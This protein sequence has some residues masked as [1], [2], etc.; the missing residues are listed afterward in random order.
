MQAIPRI[1]LRF[2]ERTFRFIPT[3]IQVSACLLLLV[4]SLQHC[5]HHQFPSLLRGRTKDNP[6]TLLIEGIQAL[7]CHFR[8]HTTAASS[9]LSPH[10]PINLLP[11]LVLSLL[12]PPNVTGRQPHAPLKQFALYTRIS[13]S[14]NRTLLKPGLKSP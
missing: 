8:L 12:F 7:L 4:L 10:P 2:L 14:T 13:A 1:M 11:D 9:S 6:P 5:L 3:A